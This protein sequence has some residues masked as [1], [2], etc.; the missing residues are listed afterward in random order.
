L[1]LEN[2]RSSNQQ[3]K[4]IRLLD[5]LKEDVKMKKGIVSVVICIMVSMG[6][7]ACG[8]GSSSSDTNVASDT[9]AAIDSVSITSISPANAILGI[10]TSFV[11]EVSYSLASKDS[12]L[13][14][15]GF[16]TDQVDSYG[17]ISSQTYTVAKGSGTHM[18]TATATPANWGPIGTFQAYVNL[19]ENPRPSSWT[20]LAGD[21]KTISISSSPAPVV[22]I[23]ANVFKSRT[24]SVQCN[25]D[26]CF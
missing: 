9:N 6:L 23:S 3:P 12:G 19:S 7:F 20:P 22:G 24:N 4:R 16:N 13:L 15:V 26:V 21:K 25:N 10:S 14:M 17:M 18:F 11:V 1:A 2:Y 8:G 5:F